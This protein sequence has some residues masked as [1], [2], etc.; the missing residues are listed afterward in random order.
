MYKI[1]GGAFML[2][3]L[4]GCSSNTEQPVAKQKMLDKRS[5]L[6]TTKANQS[7]PRT[8]FDEFIRESA[9]RY[10]VDETLI[11]AIIEVE[12]NFRPEVVSKS[13]AIG[14]M[15]IKASTAGRDA[16][17]YHGKSGEPS[18]R[19]LK[20]P[21]KNIDIGTTYI[22]ILKEQHLAGINHP[23]TLYYA[24][25][26]AYVNGAGALLRTFDND[27]GRAIAMINSLSPEEFYQHVQTKHPAP[28][29]PRY[30]WKVKNAYNA[31]GTTDF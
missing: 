19:D 1:V 6:P 26:V 15:Q 3:L 12:S 24:T 27:K 22:R 5:N 9:S 28:Q 11:R 18:S 8:P 13:N 10:S 7:F 29:A 20:D 21:K 2:L 25:V 16:Y 17:R 23:E 30:L 14:L 4:A 31:L